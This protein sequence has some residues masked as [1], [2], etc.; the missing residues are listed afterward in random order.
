MEQRKPWKFSEICFRICGTCVVLWLTLG[1]AA[2]AMNSSDAKS[3]A[4]V[5]FIGA[6]LSLVAGIIGSIWDL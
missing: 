3:F 4:A 1:V 2:C 6:A 5:F